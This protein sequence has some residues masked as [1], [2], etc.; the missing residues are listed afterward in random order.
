[1]DFLKLGAPTQTEVRPS[2]TLMTASCNNPTVLQNNIIALCLWCCRKLSCDNACGRD[3]LCHLLYRSIHIFMLWLTVFS[4]C[5]TLILL[6][7]TGSTLIHNIL[8][9][10]IWLSVMGCCWNQHHG[11]SQHLLCS[12]I[13]FKSEPAKCLFHHE[14]RKTCYCSYQD[15]WGGGFNCRC[16]FIQLMLWTY[17]M[18]HRVLMQFW[19]ISEDTGCLPVFNN[20]K[21]SLYKTFSHSDVWHQVNPS[22]SLSSRLTLGWFGRVRRGSG[23]C[24]LQ[25]VLLF[26]NEVIM[27]FIGPLVQTPTAASSQVRCWCGIKFD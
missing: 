11:Q 23:S 26:Q 17:T 25:S 5:C 1:M 9:K 7:Q 13:M 22:S 19:S 10:I 27:W 3:S 24:G 14:R 6:R 20:L 18:S 15:T 8:S 21:E 12:S 2:N 4:V 16:S